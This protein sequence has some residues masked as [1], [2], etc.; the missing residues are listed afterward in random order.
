MFLPNGHVIEKSKWA[1]ILMAF[2][3]FLLGFSK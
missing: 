1:F 2:M 3:G